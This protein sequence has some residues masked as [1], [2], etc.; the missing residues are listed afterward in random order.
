[1]TKPMTVPGSEVSVPVAVYCTGTAGDVLVLKSHI[2]SMQTLEVVWG[3]PGLCKNAGG[4]EIQSR[5]ILVANMYSRHEKEKLV[6]YS[7]KSGFFGCS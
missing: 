3:S 1:M 4:G 5:A 6:S 2:S 7:V